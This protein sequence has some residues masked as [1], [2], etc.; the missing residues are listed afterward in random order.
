MKLLKKIKEFG[1]YLIEGLYSI[2][3]GMSTI[4]LFSDSMEEKYLPKRK[5]EKKDYQNFGYQALKKGWKIVGNDL[6]KAINDF[7]RENIL[8]K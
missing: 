8:K 5:S 4:T 2:G 1:H 7:E 3:E 6:E